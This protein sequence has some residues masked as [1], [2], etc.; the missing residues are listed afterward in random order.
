MNRAH[1]A[2]TLLS[3][4]LLCAPVAAG[5]HEGA[6]ADTDKSADQ[7]AHQGA[8]TVDKVIER[9]LGQGPAETIVL[10]QGAAIRLVLHV[11]AGIELHL[12]GYDLTAEADGEAPVIMTFQADRLGRFAI[13]AHGVKDALGRSHKAFAYIEV[14]PE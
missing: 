9:R 2:T 5:A 7:S 3:A 10:P 11:S 14:R 8:A 4:L 6:H 13:E 1:R 12:H